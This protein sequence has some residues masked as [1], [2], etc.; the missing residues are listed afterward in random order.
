MLFIRPFILK[1][2]HGKR[3]SGHSKEE[4]K[5]HIIQ[6]SDVG[7]SHDLNTADKE[8]DEDNFDFGEV[9]VISHCPQSYLSLAFRLLILL[10]NNRSTVVKLF[11]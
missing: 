3:K 11:V 7:T 6:D 10:V 5:R 1:S 9:F 2:R 4:E 8:D